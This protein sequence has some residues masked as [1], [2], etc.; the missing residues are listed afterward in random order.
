MHEQL[1]AH[2][3]E[4]VSSTVSAAAAS[5]LTFPMDVVK[6]RLQ[7]QDKLTLRQSLVGISAKVLLRFFF[8][9]ETTLF[10]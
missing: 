8:C 2:T 9:V 1:K 7:V 3:N 10:F 4:V 6:T 5:A